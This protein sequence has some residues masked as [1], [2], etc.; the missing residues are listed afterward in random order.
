MS[1]STRKLEKAKAASGASSTAGG[2]LSAAAAAEDKERE[3]WLP[4]IVTEGI[5]RAYEQDHQLPKDA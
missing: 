2:E 5:L 3:N 4:S 1:S